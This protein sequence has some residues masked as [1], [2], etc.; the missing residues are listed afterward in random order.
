[1]RRWNVLTWERY[2]YRMLDIIFRISNALIL[3]P[4]LMMIVLPDWWL[5]RWIVYSYIVPFILC[6]AYLV[7][8]L[9]HAGDLWTN[10]TFYSLSAL[11]AI[12]RKDEILLIGWMHYL[13]FDLLVGCWILKDSHRLQILHAVV[14]PCLLLTFLLGPVGWL[15]YWVIRFVK[16][17]KVIHL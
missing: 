9:M 12:F 15:L 7:L 14:V 2:R 5:T 16:T 1:M 8:L 13:A 6:T 11:K 17:K 4:W 3:L 10:G